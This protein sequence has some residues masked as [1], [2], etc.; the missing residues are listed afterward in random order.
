MGKTVSKVN[1]E[2]KRLRF[3]KELKVEAARVLELGQ[4][5]ATDLAMALEGVSKN[6]RAL[7]TR[8]H[9]AVV[10]GRE[11]GLRNVGEK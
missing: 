4:K 3:S 5:P 9:S 6:L 8:I 1:P 11:G 2:R 10:G 7:D